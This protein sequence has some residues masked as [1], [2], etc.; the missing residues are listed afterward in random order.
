[1]KIDTMGLDVTIKD[2]IKGE[3]LPII[4][5]SNE[6]EKIF[7]EFDTFGNGLEH[8]AEQFI[9]ALANYDEQ[10]LVKLLSEFANLEVKNV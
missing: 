2:F 7:L 6:D 5:L 3:K 4:T 10:L 8:T 1:M 9:S